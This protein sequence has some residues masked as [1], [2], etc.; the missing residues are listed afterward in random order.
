MR[1]RK[2]IYL[3]V[4]F[5][6]AFLLTISM[7][8]SVA[9]VA[10]PEARRYLQQQIASGR[11]DPARADQTF[12]FNRQQYR[13]SDFE[14]EVGRGLL[15]LFGRSNRDQAKVTLQ[16]YLLARAEVL[17]NTASPKRAEVMENLNLLFDVVHGGAGTVE[18]TKG[19]E[20]LPVESTQD[21][22]VADL[23][24]GI[25]ETE[26]STGCSELA[27]GQHRLF[28][29]D[30]QNQYTSGNYLLRRRSDG[31]YQA[32][33][34]LN[35]VSDRGSVAPSA[36]LE[37][38][39]GCLQIA[40]SNIRGPAGERLEIVALGQEDI[41]RIPAS[42]RPSAN[43]ISITPVGSRSFSRAYASNIECPVIVHEVMHLLGLC[44][45]YQEQATDMASNNWTCRVVTRAPSIMRELSVFERAIPATVTCECTSP[46][47]R[48]VMNSSDEKLKKIYLGQSLSEVV[49]HEFRTSYCREQSLPSGGI[50]LAQS[51]GSL[52]VQ[53]QD[54][55]ITL[56]GRSLGASTTPATPEVL[57]RRMTCVCPANNTGC[58]AEARRIA[59]RALAGH[60]RRGCPSDLTSAPLGPVPDHRPPGFSFQNNRIT[61]VSPPLLPSVLLPNHFYKILEGTCSGGRSAG[62]Q[63]CA[64]FAYRSPPCN[65]PD[66]CRDDSFY[67]GAHR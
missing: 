60:P 34:H 33:L 42:E 55:G 21:R 37:R 14:P 35:F 59:D 44:D 18:L 16:N 17:R 25:R 22:T 38:A 66:R 52:V 29:S 11:I 28:A 12:V 64:S 31:T 27:P 63:E 49:P 56:E 13:L 39:Q 41:A 15:E 57:R 10:G 32:M 46:L 2:R 26:R 19:L 50:S 61:L 8:L 54:N 1:L 58:L 45:E 47:C 65:V 51:G 6:K 30:S 53:S 7:I 24:N 3:V 67:L 40:S 23:L 36:M 20:C 9:A 48:R 43:D 5:M 4:K 62:Y